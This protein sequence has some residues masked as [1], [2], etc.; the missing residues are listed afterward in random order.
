MSALPDGGRTWH[1]PSV[2]LDQMFYSV[3]CRC[4]GKRLIKSNKSRPGDSRFRL[5][6]R[7]IRCRGSPSLLTP[8][9]VHASVHR[10]ASLML[11]EAAG[12]LIGVS[13]SQR[14]RERSNAPPLHGVWGTVVRIPRPQWPF[15]LAGRAWMHPSANWRV[16]DSPSGKS[17]VT[18]GSA[19]TPNRLSP[20]TSTVYSITSPR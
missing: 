8:F 5:A 4:A 18:V 14:K 7:G 16:T 1:S 11:G 9:G 2:I 3:N 12:T 15:V 19:S 17:C 13:G 20:F 10:I 6:G